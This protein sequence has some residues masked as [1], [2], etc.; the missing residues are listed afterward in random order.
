LITDVDVAPVLLWSIG[1]YAKL[2]PKT[3]KQS[4]IGNWGALRRR[5]T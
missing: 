4:V 2:V 1:L 5:T 3:N